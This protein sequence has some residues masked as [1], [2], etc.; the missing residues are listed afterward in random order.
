ML[1]PGPSDYCD[2]P[3]TAKPRLIVVVDTEEEFDWSSE[4]SRSNVSVSTMAHIDR[5]Q[6][7]FDRYRIVPVYMVDYPVVSKPEGY[8]PLRDIY[9]SGRCLIGAHVH[10]WV[11]PPYD[12]CVS[13]WNS[14]P[15]NLPPG[16]EASKLK[17][18]GDCIGE[19]FGSRPTMYKAGRYGVGRHT[20][21]T[22]L[23][24]G[25]EVDLSVCPYMDYSPEGG[26]DFSTN[27]YKPYWIRKPLLLELPLTVGFSGMLRRWGAS[28]HRRASSGFWHSCR[29][30]GALARLGLVNKVWLSPEGYETSEHRALTRALLKDG[31]RVFSFVFHSP[32]V[33]PGHTPYV[34]SQADLDMFLSR[35]DRFFE[36]FI[37]ALGGI[38]TTPPALKR[39]LSG[40]MT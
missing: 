20:A 37:G 15:G 11:N 40:L 31:L 19:R 5:V 26:A 13:R 38:P 34:R 35:C 21:E 6:A 18:L 27:S 1:N 33:E 2:L 16:L 10:P 28:I 22:L 4:F 17:I 24:Q 9:A 25:Y 23:E 29:A 3:E 12:E 30:V 36:F 32:S 8:G 39:E 14:F 7:I